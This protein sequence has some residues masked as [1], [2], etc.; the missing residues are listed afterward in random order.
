MAFFTDDLQKDAHLSQ[1]C[2]DHV[3]AGL[4]ESLGGRLKKVVLASDGC[5][6]QF[7]SK[8]PFLLLSKM[9]RTGVSFEKVFFGARHGKN[10][11]DWSGG[12][13]KR[14]VTRDLATGIAT[15]RSAHDM[16]EHCVKTLTVSASDGELC[17]HKTRHFILLDKTVRAIRSSDVQTVVGSRKLHHVRAVASR[18]LATRQL[19]CFCSC[20]RVGVYQQ[21]VNKSHVNNWKLVEMQYSK[22]RVASESEESD[23]GVVATIPEPSSHSD[24]S[25]FGMEE[26][27]VVDSD[28]SVSSG[29]EPEFVSEEKRD[30]EEPELVSEEEINA[31]G[32]QRESEEENSFDQPEL[33]S[34]ERIIFFQSK[35]DALAACESF[36]EV[37]LLSLEMKDICQYQVPDPRSCH[38][39]HRIDANSFSLLP[40]DVRR[41]CFP[42]M[43]GADGNCFFRS[44]SVLLFGVE[45]LHVELRVRIVVCMATEERLFLSGDVWCPSFE[46]N[47]SP[48]KVMEMTVLTSAASQVSSTQDAFRQEVMAVVKAG[49]FAGLWEFFAASRALKRPIQSV[50]PSLGWG[51]YQKHCNRIIRAPGCVSDEKLIVMWTSNRDDMIA[52]HWSPN[53]FVPLL[54]KKRTSGVPKI[55]NFS[56]VMWGGREYVGQ[57]METDQ[58]LD[59]V[60]V[61]FMSQR[62]SGL[63]FWPLEDEFSWEPSVSII[64][65]V[66]LQL[67]EEAST[68]RCQLF[69]ICCV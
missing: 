62:S 9:N 66:S 50:F 20:C 33:V 39:C 52:A 55:G 65:E 3:V 48:V 13:I 53:H 15:I 28:A 61:R 36:E 59:L 49:S 24:D 10:D 21:C 7:K 60:C 30:S 12:A 34:E 23:D 47:L 57:V 68:Q 16:Y 42:I 44:L 43:V 56:L 51:C 38:P 17:Q 54:L 29:E 32:E 69:R 46:V 25:E 6:A 35:A 41:R 37:K 2:I 8:L 31:A 14:A 18:L 40:G 19:S 1:M 67:V 22:S 5:A 45:D 4:V 63:W 58:L 64:R 11:S 27:M 26:D